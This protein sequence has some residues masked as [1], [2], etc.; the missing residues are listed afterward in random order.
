MNE[1]FRRL[2]Y[3]LNRRRFEEELAS[4]MQFHRGMVAIEGGGTRSTSV[5]KPVIRGAGRG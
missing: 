3:L 4:D 1:F 2:R 5:R